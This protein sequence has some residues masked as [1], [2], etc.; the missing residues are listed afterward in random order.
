MQI[1]FSE[2]SRRSEKRGSAKSADIIGS[3]LREIGRVPL[4]KPY[5]EIDLGHQVQTM[6][7]LLAIR[8][9]IE[10]TLG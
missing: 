9:D 10:Q 8:N 6:M 3:Y 7:S 5:E 2:E 4:L 1:I